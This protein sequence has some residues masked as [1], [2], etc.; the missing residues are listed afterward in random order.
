[1]SGFLKVIAGLMIAVILSLTVSK[2]KDLSLLIT[3]AACIMTAVAAIT[4]L[5]PVVSFFKRLQSMTSLNSELLSVL[6]KATGIGV[7]SEIT[8]LICEDAGQASLS[9]ALKILSSGIM[10]FLCIPLFTELMDLINE[11]LVGI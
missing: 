3:L 6:L 2:Q 1:M 11:I 4:Y 7:L 10:L 9:K 8:C 5:V